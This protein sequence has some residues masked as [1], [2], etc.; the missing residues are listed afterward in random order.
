[1]EK[2]NISALWIVSLG[3]LIKEVGLRSLGRSE[4]AVNKTL[5]T[6]GKKY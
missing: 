3:V 5:N 2:S 1:M 4:Q 6:T